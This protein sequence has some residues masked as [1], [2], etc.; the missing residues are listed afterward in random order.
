[1]KHRAVLM[2]LMTGLVVGMSCFRAGL[3]AS[4]F[5]KETEK[6]KAKPAVPK[7]PAL[8]KFMRAKL[9]CNTCHICLTVRSTTVTTDCTTRIRIKHN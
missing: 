9:A 8:Q 4:A 6:A 7:K 5:E 1:M 2:L 3:P